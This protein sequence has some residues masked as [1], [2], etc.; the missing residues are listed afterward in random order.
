MC[1]GTQVSLPTCGLC[2]VQTYPA[3]IPGRDAPCQMQV[4]HRMSRGSFSP[5]CGRQWP[6][7]GLLGL[8]CCERLNIW[9]SGVGA[10]PG[11]PHTD[12]RCFVWALLVLTDP[13]GMG[14][15]LF[16]FHRGA[17]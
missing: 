4:N 2:F 8:L 3:D 13:L 15:A 5:R 10:V 6:S 16:P 17:R 1:S 14:L 11:I 9:I 12:S 7:L